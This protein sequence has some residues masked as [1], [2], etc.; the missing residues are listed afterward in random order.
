[1]R[2]RLDRVGKFCLATGHLTKHL[3]LAYGQTIRWS[4]KFLPCNGT[5]T[6]IPYKLLLGSSFYKLTLMY[7]E[8]GISNTRGIQI[9]PAKKAEYVLDSSRIPLQRNYVP[10]LYN[11]FPPSGV[12]IWINLKCIYMISYTF[13]I[14]ISKNIRLVIFVFSLLSF[15]GN[16]IYI[17]LIRNDMGVTK[18]TWVYPTL[19][20]EKIIW[21]RIYKIKYVTKTTAYT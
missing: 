9:R 2:E 15:T 18:K 13:E 16:M 12:I 21:Q 17:W 4:Q 8:R 14:R 1:M 20:L 19:Y 5:S 11:G 6:I 7:K 3:W 10:F